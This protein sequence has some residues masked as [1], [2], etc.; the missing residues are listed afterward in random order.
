[1]ELTRARYFAEQGKADD[2]RAQFEAAVAAAPTR[3][4]AWQ[5]YVNFCIARQDF[6][7]AEPVAERALAALPGNQSVIALREQIRVLKSDPGQTDI[8][9]RADARAKAPAS[10]EA[11]QNLRILQQAGERGELNTPE[12]LV[13][14]ADRYPTSVPIQMFVA[15]RLVLSDPA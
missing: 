11:A 8:K 1:K 3:A 9:A 5:H 2:A 4:A 12:G 10:A 7:G 13:R 14:F 6:A 15:R